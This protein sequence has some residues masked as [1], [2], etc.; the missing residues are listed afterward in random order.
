MCN[1]FTQKHEQYEDKAK[2]KEILENVFIRFFTVSLVFALH[3]YS[4]HFTVHI[5]KFTPYRITCEYL[6]VYSVVDAVKSVKSTE[7]RYEIPE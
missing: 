5:V 4:T 6:T 1:E 7:N 3:Y 2:T